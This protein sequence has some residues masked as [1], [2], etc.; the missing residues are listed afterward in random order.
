[1]TN[2]RV[3]TRAN[4]SSDFMDNCNKSFENIQKKLEN[5]ENHNNKIEDD[6][7]KMKDEIINNLM[8]S[9]LKLQEK[10]KN[11]E[12]KLENLENNNKKTTLN[13]EATNQ[14][15]RRKNIEISGI[16]NE[17]SDDVLE[18]KVIE[19]LDKIDVQ[20]TE[21]EIEACHRLPPTRNNPTKKTVV[22]F[23]NRKKAEK[24]LK[25]KKNLGQVDM[26]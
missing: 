12:K 10:V 19:I 15:G 3:S 18:Q 24:T 16:T 6:L 14:Y 17:V 4:V 23:V 7:S 5:L 8:E 11:L 21:A 1:M 13:V 22:R 26:K 9:N 2:D 25:N 20:V